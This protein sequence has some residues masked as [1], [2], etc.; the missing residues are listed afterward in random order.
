[1]W[2][3]WDPIENRNRLQPP[4]PA[5]HHFS[6]PLKLRSSSSHA[7]H[8]FTFTPHRTPLTTRVDSPTVPSLAQLKRLVARLGISARLNAAEC[9]FGNGS[10]VPAVSFSGAGLDWTGLDWTRLDWTGLDWTGL[11]LTGLTAV[12]S[13]SGA[14]RSSHIAPATSPSASAAKLSSQVEPSTRPAPSYDGAALTAAFDPW[15]H[16][17]LQL[18]LRSASHANATLIGWPDWSSRDLHRHSPARI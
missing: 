13:F 10:R 3:V 16:V 4:H 11:N 15:Y 2:S 7:L 8:P 6:S 12:S 1:M 5:T 9:A 18:V 14:G 17:M